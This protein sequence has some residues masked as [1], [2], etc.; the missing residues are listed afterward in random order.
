MSGAGLRGSH[1]IRLL[2]LSLSLL[3]ASETQAAHFLCDTGTLASTCEV[4]TAKGGMEGHTLS[5]AG[6]LIIR[7]GGSLSGAGGPGTTLTITLGGDLTI[8]TGGSISAN[9]E[10]A[11]ANLTV[12]PGAVLDATTHGF[13]STQGPG[14]GP[15]GGGGG[16]GGAGGGGGVAYDDPLNPTQPGSGG[17]ESGGRGACNVAGGTGGGLLHI[18]LSGTLTLNGSVSADGGG[19]SGSYNQSLCGP[20]GGGGGAGG[21]VNIVAGTVSGTTGQISANGGASGGAT[22]GG[23]GGRVAIY[24]RQAT[25]RQPIRVVGGLGANNGQAGTICLINLT[26]NQT[27][28]IGPGG[29]GE[30][31]I[32]QPP[33]A[34]PVMASP[35]SGIFVGSPFTILTSFNDPDHPVTSCEYT[36]DGTTFLA[37]TLFGSLPT[38]TCT[39][40]GL[41][42][43]DGVSLTLNMRATSAGGTGLA[44]AILRTV[45]AAAPTT[46]DNALTSWQRTDQTVTLTATDA[47]SGVALTSFCTDTLCQ[48]TTRGTLVSVT[49]ALDSV[50]QTTVRY[51]STDRVGNLESVKSAL[52]RIDKAAPTGTVL[53]NN[54]ATLTSNPTVLLS[55]TC[56]DLGAGC[57]GMQIAPD[58]VAFGPFLPFALMSTT[59]LP[60]P[61]GTKTVAVRFMDG[62]GN[63]S[64]QATADI[65]L[66]TTPPLVSIIQPAPN[67]LV[68]GTVTIEATATDALSGVAFVAFLVTDPTTGM[69]TFLG[70]LATPPYRVVWTTTPY[71]DG[72]YTLTA[73]AQD[74]AGNARSATRAVT[75]N[76]KPL[77][78]RNLGAA[79]LTFNP[80]FGEVTTLSYDLS[81]PATVTVTVFNVTTEAPVK[82]DEGEDEEE[83]FNVTTGAPVKEVLRSVSQPG[84]VRL[85]SWDGTEATGTPVAGHFAF[86]VTVTDAFGTLVTAQSAEAQ[87]I[88]TL[89]TKPVI[90]Q[91]HNRPDPFSLTS[92]EPTTIRFT[93]LTTVTQDLRV[94]IKIKDINGLVS[95]FLFNG[96]LPASPPPGTLHSVVWDGKDDVGNLAQP[97]AYRYEIT[98]RVPQ[99]PA[100]PTNVANPQAGTITVV[101]T[102]RVT[103]SADQVLTVFSHP[104]DISLTI[105]QSPTLSV[106]QAAGL[107]ARG[108]HVVSSV[109]A[110]TASG[111]LQAP[112]IVQVRYDP[113][114][115]GTALIPVA[116]NPATGRWDPVPFLL[117]QANHQVVLQTDRL[118]LFALLSNGDTTPPRIE[119]LL[120]TPAILRFTL[121]DEGTGLDLPLLRVLL[122]GQD[123]TQTLLIHA[124]E[125]NREVKVEQPFP[126]LTPTGNTLEIVAYDI[127]GN[128]ARRL[129][130]FAAA[131]TDVD[132]R[133]KPEVLKV[134]EGVLTA[135]VRFP[136]EL[137]VIR[138]ETA[139]LN[140][141]L[142]D[143]I[144]SG[145]DAEREDKDRD[146]AQEEK[147]EREFILK[148]RRTEVERA[149]EQ[150]GEVLGR[151]FVL[152]GTAHASIG[153]VMFEGRDSIR[154]V[155]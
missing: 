11:T 38:F 89:F 51:Q 132:L 61:D 138:I 84:G 115:A 36:L 120:V 112:V 113:T 134:T 12:Q 59:T 7:A 128:R 133:I 8:E 64:S 119:E 33:S 50:C 74:R 40:T 91:V 130:A 19:G 136:E 49:C 26:V 154:K 54:G 46:T 153:R 78:I 35:S 48:P 125:Q 70:S 80:A 18:V 126:L 58:G 28:C 131:F 95:R 65:L 1:L 103:V 5:G 9:V 77:T 73:T 105:T 6:N 39:K 96:L 86:T 67:A 85:V 75:V 32:T 34:G 110:V 102:T 87:P 98:A 141:A 152:L 55:L 56:T 52:V 100:T 116:L 148:F 139:T 149:L 3:V 45:D 106:E 150:A 109:Y 63:L 145:K 30:T 107:L 14:G 123:I 93:L 90:A 147:G 99:A 22:G 124:E 57:S 42:G 144:L 129:V 79:P 62:A 97:G 17:G 29:S 143:R 104:A 92:V 23:G 82:E 66:D 88:Q 10:I 135:F 4:S 71:P 155:Q 122:N 76:T 117:D 111:P 118:T 83:V 43:A 72:P 101:T 60:P 114:L 121:T 81:K 142:V 127:A 53:I 140:G 41:T 37:A 151:D 2:V 13:T 15:F 16:H 20:G 27:T 137:P 94:T 146:E 47:G 31:T 69:T 44:S 25:F 21:S 68:S 108:S 24:Y